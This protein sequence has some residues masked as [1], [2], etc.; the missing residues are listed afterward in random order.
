MGEKGK[1]TEW[2]MKGRNRNVKKK[3]RYGDDESGII[4]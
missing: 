4:I 1:E 2:K 3:K